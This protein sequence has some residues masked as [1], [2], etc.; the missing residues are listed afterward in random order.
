M[1]V[2]FNDLELIQ[3]AKQHL[4]QI[5]VSSFYYIALISIAKA[6]LSYAETNQDLTWISN[7]RELLMKLPEMSSLTTALIDV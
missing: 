7:A 2:A 4:E 6:F 5:E 1:G 3:Q